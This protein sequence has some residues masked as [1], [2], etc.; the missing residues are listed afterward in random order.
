MPDRNPDTADTPA[1]VMEQIRVR[2]NA[3]VVGTPTPFSPVTQFSSQV[4]GVVPD[5]TDVFSTVGANAF[6]R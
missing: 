5:R 6:A 3:A 4:K 1:S 2:E